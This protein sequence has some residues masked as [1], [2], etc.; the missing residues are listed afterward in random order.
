MAIVK[1]ALQALE[2][3]VGSKYFSD[4][5]VIMTA[6]KSGPGGYEAGTG[7]ERVMTTLP[8]AVILPKTGEDVQKIVKIC[9]RFNV[10]YVPWATGFYGPRSHCHVEN[11]L[12]IDMKRMKKCEFD[13]QHY[14]TVIE[15][16]VI[17]SVVQEE[18][19]KR[20]SYM[21]IGGGGAQ[22]SVLANL[23]CD[24]WSPLSLR[25]GLPHR[26]ILGLELVLP[27]GELVKL[28]S[29]AVGDDAFWG[30]GIGPDLRGILRG[31]TGLLGCMGIVTKMAVKS[32]PFQP[33]PLA[34]EGISPTTALT[35]PMKRIKWINYQVPSKEAENKSMREIGRALIGGAV[36][37]VPVF[38]RAIA[39]AE[40]KEEFWDIWDKETPE[41]L[42]NFHLVRVLLIGFTSEEQMIYDENV[43]NDIFSELGG[44]PRPTK[45]SDQSW[46]KNADSA[47]MWLMCG[48]YVSVDYIIESY[49]HA[50]VHGPE[51]A[52]L[53]AQY[54][55]PLMPDHGD[56]G[57][58]MGVEGGHNGYSEYLIYWDQREDISRVDQ[59][60]VETSKMN[61][62]HGFYT[63]LLSSHQPMY[64]TGPAYG[65]NYHNWILKLKDD[66]DPQWICHPPVP[67]AHDEFVEKSPWMM[68]IK[69]WNTPK[70]PEEWPHNK[71][72]LKK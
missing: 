39:K 30:E 53:K 43:L 33:E 47:G 72:P 18:C 57:W 31:Y 29:L 36:T 35:L 58:T 45:P 40:G 1:E 9:S 14:Y 48:S 64:L 68:E 7:Y 26:R 11:E 41:S 10:P 16:G 15:S 56:P 70:Y 4:D 37:K 44:K 55:P 67:L 50:E 12:I 22:T 49:P 66:L 20:G 19:M 54:T 3:V 24:G 25:V 38:W 5:P 17:A 71:V 52:K 61:I 28:G 51:Y 21:V 27:D 42:E 13:D 59:F 23:I 60:Y 62:K 69:D 46:I 8:A 2:A 6:Y 34:P 65:P 63:S 32:L